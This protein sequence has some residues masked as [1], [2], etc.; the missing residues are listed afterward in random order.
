MFKFVYRSESVSASE[1]T[2][3]SAPEIGPDGLPVPSPQK[4]RKKVDRFD[5]IPEEEVAKKFLPDHLGPNMDI[6]IVSFCCW[7]IYTNLLW[8]IAI[9]G[10]VFN[11]T[12]AQ[13]VRKKSMSDIF[14]L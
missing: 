6:L 3:R 8:Y 9:L 13:I 2:K 5:G 14:R 10:L 4:Q 1:T 12:L 11:G 7:H